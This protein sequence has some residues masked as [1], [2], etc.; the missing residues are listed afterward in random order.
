MWNC[1][2]G[3][4]EKECWPLMP[5]DEIRT[6]KHHRKESKK[7]SYMDKKMPFPSCCSIQMIYKQ[8]F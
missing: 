1:V 3:D 7:P 4:G 6:G 2:G 5:D 8:C